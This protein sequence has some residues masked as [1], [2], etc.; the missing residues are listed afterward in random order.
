MQRTTFHW[1]LRWRLHQTFSSQ[2]APSSWEQILLTFCMFLRKTWPFLS[3]RSIAWFT[4]GW[5]L[6]LKLVIKNTSAY[7]CEHTKRN[8]STSEKS[9]TSLATSASSVVWAKS[10]ASLVRSW[11]QQ[12]CPECSM[13]LWSREFTAF[14][15]TSRMTRHTTTRLKRGEFQASLPPLLQKKI[16]ALDL[17]PS[18]SFDSLRLWKKRKKSHLPFRFHW[19]KGTLRLHKGDRFWKTTGK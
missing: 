9:T 10:S 13:Q 17:I 5:L 7:S 12:W 8:A 6:K 19:R 18:Q 1:I 15:T 3:K 4:S 16:V 2:K 14:S 11:R